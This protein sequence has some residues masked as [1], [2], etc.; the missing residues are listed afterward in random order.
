M[1]SSGKKDKTPT[2]LSGKALFELIIAAMDK[3][4]YKYR[5][6]E[7]KLLISIKFTV[8]GISIGLIIRAF[9]DRPIIAFDCPFDFE[10]DEN[11]DEAVERALR[12]INE[13]NGTVDCG[14]FTLQNGRV[15][16]LLHYKIL[17]G[18]S[19]EEILDLLQMSLNIVA[20]KTEELTE[21][22][23]KTESS[24][25]EYDKFFS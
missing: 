10:I 8:D 14:C 4:Q 20:E 19:L 15:W 22:L 3:K 21:K 24:H 18:I 1:A 16:Y 9:E 7:E 23:T 6:N 2:G 12:E 25:E 5:P 13:L 11:D 17:D